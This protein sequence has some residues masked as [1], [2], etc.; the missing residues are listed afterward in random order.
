MTAGL[1]PG[2]VTLGAILRTAGTVEFEMALAVLRNLSSSNTEIRNAAWAQFVKDGEYRLAPNFIPPPEPE[3]EPEASAAHPCWC[4]GY[5]GN[6]P[7][8]KALAGCP[9]CSSGMVPES[10]VWV[11]CCCAGYAKECVCTDRPP[12]TSCGALP[13][14]CICPDADTRPA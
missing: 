6:A 2:V 10:S 1:L 11:C 7:V 5:E 12:C 4:C 13:L 14:G 8:F 9:E 3:P